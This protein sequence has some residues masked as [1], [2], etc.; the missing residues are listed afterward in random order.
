MTSGNISNYGCRPIRPKPSPSI[1]NS[2]HS[3]LFHS[4]AKNQTI[5]SHP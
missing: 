2:V 3:L 1:P 5:L 4:L